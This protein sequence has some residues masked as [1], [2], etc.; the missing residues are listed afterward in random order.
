VVLC[1]HQYSIPN[2][3]NNLR[4][5][6]YTRPLIMSTPPLHVPCCPR[7]LGVFVLLRLCFAG[8]VALGQDCEQRRDSITPTGNARDTRQTRVTGTGFLGGSNC[9]PV[10][11]PVTTRDLNP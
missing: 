8:R 2:K 1:S 10:P 7:L 6:L 5:T 11:V 4:C 3:N 9:Q